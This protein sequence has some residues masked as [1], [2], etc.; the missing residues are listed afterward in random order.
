MRELYFNRYLFYTCLLL[1]GGMMLIDATPL[2]GRL[3]G[4]AKEWVDPFLDFTGLWQNSWALFAPSPDQVNV[5]VGAVI[6]WSDGEISGPY[7]QPNWQ[8]MTATQK[9]RSFREMAYFDSLWRD[10]FSAAWLPYCQKLLEEQSQN[11]SRVAVSV[12]LFCIQDKILP[13]TMDWRP[14]Y[15]PPQFDPDSV[16]LLYQWSPD[17]DEGG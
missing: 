3:H 16:Q 6:H 10:E 17:S 5:Q 7:Y 2:I 13:P 8:A 14:A 15:S 9:M 4:R 1:V 11:S 12:D